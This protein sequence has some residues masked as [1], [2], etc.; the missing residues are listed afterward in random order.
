MMEILGRV[1]NWNNV[2]WCVFLVCRYSFFMAPS[3]FGSRW[4]DLYLD[5]DL[6]VIVSFFTTTLLEGCSVVLACNK[7][8]LR[9]VRS[10]ATLALRKYQWSHPRQP[11]L[12]VTVM[13]ISCRFFLV[14][15]GLL[16]LV[17]VVLFLVAGFFWI[18]MPTFERIDS[19]VDSHVVQLSDLQRNDS[20]YFENTTISVMDSQSQ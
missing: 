13:R 18:A 16:V 1:L 20:E 17:F 2:F 14:V 7:V 19:V 3:L 4:D 9:W 10:K 8:T 12:Y 11:T 6:N 5:N 15:C